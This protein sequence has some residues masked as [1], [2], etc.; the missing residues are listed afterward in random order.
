[1]AKWYKGRD[2]FEPPPIEH[3]GKVYTMIRS[4][5]NLFRRMVIDLPTAASDIENP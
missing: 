5:I 1:M 4:K 2:P 3:N